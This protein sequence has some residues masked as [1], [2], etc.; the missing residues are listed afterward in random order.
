[1]L[2]RLSVI[3]ALNLV[4]ASLSLAQNANTATPTTRRRTSTNS[5]TNQA[6]PPAAR[7]IEE[8][9]IEP[10]TPPTTQQPRARRAGVNR[11]ESSSSSAGATDPTSRGVLSAFN[12]LLDG[13]RAAD[14]AA[15]S[16]AY[17]RSTQLT[18]FNYNGTVTKGWEQ[19][20]SNRASS[21]PE[22]KN[23][24][25]DVRDVRVQMLGRD[26][27]LV[28]CLWRQSQTFHDA[29]ETSSGRMTLVFRRVGNAW[30][31]VHLHTSPDAPDPSRVPPSEQTTE[32]T[33]RPAATP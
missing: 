16:N 21:Y 8:R 22:I 11:A 14:V 10:S 13:I 17:W 28:T 12:S 26:G 4:L 19:M 7:D 18:L 5:N 33:T 1:M 23:V 9:S 15:V 25:L 30:K 6:T 32:Q 27:A 2:K 20:R 3:I 29:P 24:K 31:A